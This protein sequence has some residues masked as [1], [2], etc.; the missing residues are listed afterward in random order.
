LGLLNSLI[1]AFPLLAA[2]KP[3]NHAGG[4]QASSSAKLVQLVREGTNAYSGACE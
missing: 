3:S 4:H 1:I 2:E